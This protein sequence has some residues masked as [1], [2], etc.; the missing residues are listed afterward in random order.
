MANKTSPNRRIHSAEYGNAYKNNDRL[1]VAVTNLL[2]ADILKLCFVPGGTFVDRVVVKNTDMDTGA[3][4]LS[5]AKIGFAPVD[6]TA[7]AA[8]SDVIVSATA[9]FGQAAATTTYEIF[10]PF[11]VEL[12]SWLTIVIGAAPATAAAGTIEA[13]V[14][15]EC[16]GVR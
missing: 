11:R 16:I 13:K 2:V 12:D 4:P 10:P 9:A 7:A 14:E 8:G 6:G 5:T 3:T 1:T 15:G